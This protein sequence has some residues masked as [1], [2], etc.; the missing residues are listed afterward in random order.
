MGVEGDAMNAKNVLVAVLAL[1]LTSAVLAGPSLRPPL[2]TRPDIPSACE[3]EPWNCGSP[4]G[5]FVRRI[6]AMLP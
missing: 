4:W 1:I 5:V 6:L 2:Q 3:Y